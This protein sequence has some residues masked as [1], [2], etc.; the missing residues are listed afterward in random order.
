MYFYLLKLHYSKTFKS[1]FNN[2]M[3]FLIYNIH[4]AIIKRHDYETSQP[5]Q[6]QGKGTC[7]LSTEC[8]LH[9]R[10]TSIIQHNSPLI[11]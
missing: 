5:S 4:D 11:Q 3:N 7:Q 2:I 1:P 6:E 10:Y 9:P 8:L